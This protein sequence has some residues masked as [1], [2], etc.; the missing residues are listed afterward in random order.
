[1]SKITF[2]IGRKKANNADCCDTNSDQVI[3]QPIKQLLGLCPQSHASDLS[4]FTHALGRGTE[5][6]LWLYIYI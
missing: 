1:M 5:Q 4:G 6:R 3:N 2:P